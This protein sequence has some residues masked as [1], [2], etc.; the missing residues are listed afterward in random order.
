MGYLYIFIAKKIIS[1][2][3]GDRFLGTTKQVTV[4]ENLA[5]G[6]TVVRVAAHDR[7]VGDNAAVTYFLGAGSR[8][9][10]GLGLL[11]LHGLGAGSQALYGLGLGLHSL[12]ALSQ[13]LH[14]LGLRGLGAGSQ[15]LYGDVFSV[16]AVS[17]DLIVTGEVDRERA[18][19]YHVMVG[20][21]DAGAEPLV[22]E[23]TVIVKVCSFAHQIH[24]TVTY[25]HIS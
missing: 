1:W 10:H 20:A 15:A 19:V 5:V 6:T 17:G 16:D 7:D 22:D 24:F 8:V 12:I 25:T 9:L 4:T 23:T 21:R 18:A 13:V 11:G 2:T 14:G 3:V